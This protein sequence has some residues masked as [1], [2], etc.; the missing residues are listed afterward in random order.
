M[1]LLSAP[2]ENQISSDDPKL[3]GN[4][5][6]IRT[7]QTANSDVEL[8]PVKPLDRFFRSQVFGHLRQIREASLEVL[9]ARGNAHFGD[10]KSDVKGMI[11][12]RDPRFYRAAA[13][14]GGLGVAEGYLRGD[15]E[16]PDLTSTLRVLARNLGRLEEVERGQARLLKS[17]QRFTSVLRRNTLSGSRR[18]IA[19]H[20]DLSNEFFALMLDPTMTYSSGIFSTPR[21][22][23]ED[24]SRKKYDRICRELDLRPADRV[25]EIGTG[26]GG[27]A[28]HAARH[29]GCRIDTTTI[30]NAQFQYAK[31]RITAAGLEDR[32][33][34]MNKDYRELRGKYDKLVSIEMIEAVGE[35]Y[36]PT[37]FECC[38]AL[39]RSGGQ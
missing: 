14:G 9:D 20:Y 25:I 37:F 24:A 28:E 34:I 3:N 4:P 19:A 17:L 21:A 16:T 23:L 36:L 7:D 15:W 22:S 18:N 29:Y 26:W 12:V 8:S 5:I 13:L 1:P 31:Q 32:I 2:T 35:K 33:T 39:L 6:G 38:S 27:F 30:S 11:E 10:G